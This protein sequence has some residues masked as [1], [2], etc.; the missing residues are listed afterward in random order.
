MKRD[1][2]KGKQGVSCQPPVIPDRVKHWLHVW[3][4][5]DPHGHD[6]W[7]GKGRMASQDKVGVGCTYLIVNYGHSATA[8]SKQ[9]KLPA[10]GDTIAYMIHSCIKPT[11]LPWA[12]RPLTT[13]RL[14][15]PLRPH[16]FLEDQSNCTLLCR[17][18]K[19]LAVVHGTRYFNKHLSRTG[20]QAFGRTD[21][22]MDL[23][24][25]IGSYVRL[26]IGR[27]KQTE[28]QRCQ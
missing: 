2:R 21:H 13:C 14:G 5:L 23:P 3:E 16:P 4:G 20:P 27:L 12:L 28:G 10:E 25:S 6:P 1:S 19:G 26:K 17:Y 24:L 8:T 9:G 7:L 18:I 11:R 22:M 15:Y